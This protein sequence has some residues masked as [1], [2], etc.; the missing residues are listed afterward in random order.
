MPARPFPE[1]PL[2]LLWRPS[3]LFFT[4]SRSPFICLKISHD[5]Y[6]ISTNT[7]LINWLW[8]FFYTFLIYGKGIRNITRI[9]AKS[10]LISEAFRWV[11]VTWV[12]KVITCQ[13]QIVQAH[14]VWSL[15][16]VKIDIHKLRG[17]NLRLKWF[18]T[19][20]YNKVLWK[21]VQIGG[22]VI[23][24]IEIDVGWFF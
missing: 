14:T 3:R 1:L 15:K 2:F 10:S 13:F 20:K 8:V 9:S 23:H 6:L 18:K 19:L 11:C 21:T 17:Y 12:F 4:V 16:K 5:V 24:V 7:M 22:Q